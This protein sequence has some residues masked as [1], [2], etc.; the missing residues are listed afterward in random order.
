[1]GRA[2]SGLEAYLEWQEDV[3][4]FESSGLSVDAFCQ[5]ENVSRPKFVDCLLIL[6][7]K[8][9]SVAVD[10]EARDASAEGPAFVPISVKARSVE[11]E[12]PNGSLLGRPVSSDQAVLLA[13]VH[14]VGALP[15]ESPL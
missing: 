4:G 14:V 8:P 11:I 9:R 5:Q 15:K 1:M 3:R 2:V 10:R 6:K 13:I 7:Q 12:L